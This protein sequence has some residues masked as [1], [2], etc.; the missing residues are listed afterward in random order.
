MRIDQK[1]NAIFFDNDDEFYQFAVN[2]LL[3]VTNG[4]NI[5]YTDWSFTDVYNSALAA[6]TDF[7]ICDSNSKTYKNQCVSYRTITKPVTIKQYD[8]VKDINIKRKVKNI[9]KKKESNE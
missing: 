7:I 2:P 9:T 4:D 5:P 6:K 8:K 3:T 1:R